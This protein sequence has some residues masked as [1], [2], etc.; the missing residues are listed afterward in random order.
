MRYL[1]SPVVHHL[2]LSPYSLR[3]FPERYPALTERPF[4]APYDR[5][6]VELFDAH[7][8][9]ILANY[10]LS[11]RHV[12]DRASA[13]HLT[14]EV[15]RVVTEGGAELRAR[16]VVLALGQ[17]PPSSPAWAKGSTGDTRIQHVFAAELDWPRQRERVA[18]VGGGITGA[19]ICLRL[20]E[21]G[22]DV[23][24]VTRHKFRVKQFDSEPG[25]LGPKFMRGFDKLRSYERRREEITAARHRG[26]M[27]H[28]VHKDLRAALKAGLVS[29]R[30]A[31]VR[32]AVSQPS[33]LFLAL[34]NG[35]SL[36]VDRVILATGFEGKRPGGQLVDNLVE[37]AAL[38]CADCGYP[39][40]D[41]SLRWH[42]RLLVSGPLA[43]LELGPSARNIAG[44]RAAGE[45]IADVAKSLVSE[46]Q[47]S[48]EDAAAC[49]LR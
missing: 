14:G 1:R 39:I 17:P 35:E 32:D 8:D 24:L 27:P 38:P 16:H 10:G 2:G 44:A 15:A 13:I 9:W 41:R 36:D 37:S 34:D 6:S 23:T 12:Q 29:L 49:V 5:P 40:V 42:P 25:W 18:V 4:A 22:H 20:V 46:A 43:E 21:E 33:S 45:R 3:R 11:Q 47:A 26:S 19:Q 48:V 7:C 30:Q 28:S 31:E